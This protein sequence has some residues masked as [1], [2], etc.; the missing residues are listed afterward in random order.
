MSAYRALAVAFL[1][2]VAGCGDPTPDGAIV[3]FQTTDGSSFKVE[4]H[5]PA[6]IERLR[7]ALESDGR[8]GIP[9][10]RLE[11]GDA[12]YNTGHDWH[13]VDVEMVD[14]AIEV[15]DGTA[16]MVDED[17][18]YWLET[19]GQYCPWDARVVDIVEFATL[20]SE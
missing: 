19:V 17:L 11:P 2:V 7:T 8:A 4:I 12:G 20:V 9:N 6:T 13:M 18:G 14:I 15:C 1:M 5:D 3:T 10:G 16:S